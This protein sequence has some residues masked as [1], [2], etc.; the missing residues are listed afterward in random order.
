MVCLL[1]EYVI[2]ILSKSM[3][4]VYIIISSSIS[5]SIRVYTVRT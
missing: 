3:W 1:A 2:M 4:L 5:I